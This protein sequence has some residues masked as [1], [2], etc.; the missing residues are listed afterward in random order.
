LGLI[1]LAGTAC[2]PGSVT[3]ASQTDLVVTYHMA[4]ANYQ[5]NKTYAMPDSVVDISVAAG[6]DTSLSHK[7]DAA[8][9]AQVAQNMQALGYTRVDPR[10]TKPDA[11]VLVAG[12]TVQNYAYNPYYWWGYWGW[13]YGWDGYWG[14]GPGSG[15]YWPWAPVTTTYT[16]GTIFIT[17]ADPDV[18]PPTNG[19]ITAIWSAAI[20]GLVT[21][22]DASIQG[23]ITTNI[24]QA[25]QQS[26]YLATHP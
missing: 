12:V 5:A 25:F 9:L 26:P 20:N 16:T 15:Y 2:Y 10:V 17:L 24:Q 14:Y 23:R 22:T 8:I 1:C 6:Q 7:F 4:G 19:Q 13:W 3:S 21:G 11:V 18:P